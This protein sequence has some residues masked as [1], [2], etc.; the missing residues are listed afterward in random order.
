MFAV[1]DGHGTHGHS[2][3][4]YCKKHMPG[5]IAKF[6]RQAR[7]V[8]YKA[9]LKKNK[10]KGAKVFDPEKWPLLEMEEYKVCCRKAFLQC[11][12]SMHNDMTVS[13]DRMGDRIHLVLHLTE[14]TPS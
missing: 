1:Y 5:L 12:Q 11:N 2:C 8:K 3:A 7:V 10:V 9:F 6:V 4:R 14:G 13:E